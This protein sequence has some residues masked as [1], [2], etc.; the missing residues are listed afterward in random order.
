M[1]GAFKTG[2]NWSTG[3]SYIS[4]GQ[5]APLWQ[6]KITPAVHLPARYGL[7]GN[8]LVSPPV[9]A[10]HVEGASQLFS[11]IFQPTGRL[12][13]VYFFI[14]N[15]AVRRNIRQS[16]K[17]ISTFFCANAKHAPHQRPVVRTPSTLRTNVP[18]SCINGRND[19]AFFN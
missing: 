12:L 2:K 9:P 10:C 6:T 15:P 14:L 18:L 13:I 1:S 19:F 3:G 4:H 11:K 17:R 5:P 8:G 16:F 7:C